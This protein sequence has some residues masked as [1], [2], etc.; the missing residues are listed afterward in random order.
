MALQIQEYCGHKIIYY[1]EEKCGKNK[2]EHTSIVFGP[3]ELILKGN[4][5][6]LLTKQLD[7]LSDKVNWYR[8][9]GQI[10]TCTD[11][12]NLKEIEKIAVEWNQ[13]QK[14]ERQKK[15][16]DYLKRLED[17]ITALEQE[18]SELRYAP[19]NVGY[20]EAKKHFE[21]LI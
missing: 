7:T 19:G 9:K 17:R 2:A 21:S 4:H 15:K 14:K 13:L 3:N 8:S 6:Y 10:Y 1:P 11:S 5:F 12:K 20:V 16:S 18:I